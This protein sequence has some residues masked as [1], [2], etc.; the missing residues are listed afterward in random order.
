MEV[1]DICRI[2]EIRSHLNRLKLEESKLLRPALT[3]L[4]KVSHVMDIISKNDKKLHVYGQ[5]DVN[6]HRQSQI[7][8]LLFLYSPGTIL[9]DSMPIGL[10]EA[11]SKEMSVSPSR[12]S[13]Y[14]HN[15]GFLWSTYSDFREHVEYLWCEVQARLD[16]E[17][18]M[19]P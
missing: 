9:G 15:V 14:A 4:S 12:I 10:R 13:N 11:I 5:M 18:S 7:F 19:G 8:V 17:T 1:T 6:T 3:D 16:L 2:K